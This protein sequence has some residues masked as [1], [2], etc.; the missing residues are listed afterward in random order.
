MSRYRH[1]VLVLLLLPLLLS[2]LGFVPGPQTDSNEARRAASFVPEVAELL[3]HP[4]VRTSAD[5]DPA[6]DSWR[7]VLTEEVSQT[8]VA[9]LTV[10]DDT[11]EVEGIEVYPVAETLTYPKTSKA[12]AIKLALADPEVGE[13]LR[14]HGPYT[15][16]AEYEDGEW[17]VHFEVEESGSVGGMPVEDGERKEVAQVGVDDETWQLKYVWTG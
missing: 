8:V 9:E 11:R 14:K 12:D 5:Y 7:V 10:M 3:S 6:S 17:M 4:T 16:D 13:E 15:A 2:I 1:V